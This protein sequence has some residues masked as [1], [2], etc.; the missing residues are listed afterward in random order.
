MIDQQKIIEEKLYEKISKKPRKC[1]V[2]RKPIVEHIFTRKVL[3][4]PRDIKI[5]NYNRNLLACFNPGATLENDHLYVFPRTIF[6]YYN[7][8]SSISFFKIEVE[9]VVNGSL[10][11]PVSARV[12][13]WPRNVWEF[14]GCED[15]RVYKS[16]SKYLVLYTGYG[17][18]EDV[19]KPVQGF[20]VL[21]ENLKAGRR[22]FFT[23]SIDGEK[24]IPRAM[25]DSALI[26]VEGSR[27]WMLTRPTIRDVD[28][29]WRGLADLSA[30]TLDGETLEPVL[31]PEGWELKVGWSTNVVKLSSNEY[32]VGWHGV[33]WEDYSYRNG[34]AL[35]DGQ[36][37][38]LAVSD[39]LLAPKGINEEY[40]DRALVIF[41]DGLVRYK[42]YLV[43]I[44]G[45]SDYAIGI[46]A[47]ELEKALE[48]VRWLTG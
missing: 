11:K 23:I 24:F 10:E 42:E 46:F 21:D 17:F 19:K 43:W 3:L 40:G 48:K 15:A 30:L 35:V 33:L 20:T 16:E 28:V 41:G 13:L 22:G 26:E 45:V 6:D 27:A 38:L 37:N 7:Y 29:C 34:L 25:K 14:N 8:V 32:L 9:K 5:T 1:K 4:T 18:I 36:G 31:F 12:I 39:Y 44:G 2:P 47:V